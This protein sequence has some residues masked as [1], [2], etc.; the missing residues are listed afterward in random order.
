MRHA[1]AFI[2]FLVL[3]LSLS[4]PAE[5]QQTYL[6]QAALAA[7]ADFT[8]R[9]KIAMVKNAYTMSLEGAAPVSCA[10]KEA[11]CAAKRMTLAAQVAANP[12]GWA[13]QFST[14]VVGDTAITAASTD[15]QLADRVYQIW[16]LM[17]GVQ[18]Q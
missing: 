6:Q 8:S 14:V 11:A 5:A 4:H 12:Q 2:A 18:A 16:N 15:Q 3:G 10:N 7:D 1:F 17:S 13:M 9:V